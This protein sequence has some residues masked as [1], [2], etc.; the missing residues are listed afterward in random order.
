MAAISGL[1]VTEV[2][3]KFEPVGAV[4]KKT[5]PL[6]RGAERDV[7]VLVEPAVVLVVFV[8]IQVAHKGILL[9]RP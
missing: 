9:F 5:L 8:V 6:R 7:A 3:L 2:M 4:C 1:G